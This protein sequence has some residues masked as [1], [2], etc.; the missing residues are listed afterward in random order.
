MKLAILIFRS[1]EYRLY[2]PTIEAA[3]A[4]G[5]DVECWHDYS[6]PQTGLKEYQ[7]P[8]VDSVPVFRHGQPVVRRYRGKSELRVWLAEMRA[9]AVVTGRIDDFELPLPSPRPLCVCHQYFI[10]S[11]CLFGAQSLLI[12]DVLALY[13]RWWLDWVAEYFEAEGLVS[14]RRTY[15]AEAAERAAFV[16]L[17]E[18]DTARLIDPDEVRRRW[19]IPA[20]QPVVVLFPFPQGVG[21][22]AFWPKAICGEPSRLK[23]IAHVVARR[24]FEYWP[25]VWHGWNDANVVNS[26]RR[27]C[28]R[29]G[30]YL[31]VKSRHKTPVPAYL[32]A[33][34]D[35]CV[36]DDSFYPATVL[37]ALSIASLSVSYYSNSV[38]ESVA[39]GVPHLCVT[40][41]SEDYNGAPSSYFS[42]FYTPAEGGAF[43]FRGV[44][45]AWSIPE[46]LRRLP[47]K[48]LD[49][50]VMDQEARA[51]Y[52][53]RFLTHDE[54]DGGV[55]T[56]DA[57]EHALRRAE[58]KAERASV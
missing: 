4:R 30:A 29:N 22:A 28:D 42:R 58:A 57:I 19:G 34:A 39:L 21:K 43:Q 27:F 50:F 3:L 6:Q 15:L 16:G 37:E 14:D 23:Q 26:L 9:D 46:T 1:P 41:T 24:R 13:S 51:R 5:W 32:E 10:D 44:T 25:H 45:T 2:A 54:G 55:R 7:F 53:H 52:I 17:P 8:S 18:L 31:L 56:V 20:G 36:Y 40:F 12:W 49:D 35:R 38:F 33:L 47:H 48:T 11:L